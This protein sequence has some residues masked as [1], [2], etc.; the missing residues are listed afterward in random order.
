M[1]CRHRLLRLDRCRMLELDRTGRDAAPAHAHH[2]RA[3]NLGLLV[4]GMA[5]GQGAIFAVQ[6]WLVARGQFDLL[7][8]FATHYSIAILGILVVDGGTSSRLA[9]DAAHASLVGRPADDLWR[10]FCE[11]SVFRSAI[12]LAVSIGATV[13]ATMFATSDFSR[14]YVLL[15]TP[16]W[17][18]WAWNATGLLDG[19]QRS[20]IAGITGTVPY[21]ASAAEIGRAHV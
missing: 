4:A 1:V 18:I 3:L 7:S 10:V 9:R 6:S 8:L 12:A 15:A 20:G 13:F 14:W 11:T 21:V 19:W 2:S 17:M 5:G 16:G